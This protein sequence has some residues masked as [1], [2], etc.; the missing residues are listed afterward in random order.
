MQEP[1]TDLFLCTIGAGSM[2]QTVDDI[3][4]DDG[5]SFRRTLAE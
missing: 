1:E 3:R 2:G 4:T 5:F